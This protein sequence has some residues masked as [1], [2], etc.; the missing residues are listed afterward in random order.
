MKVRTEEVWVTVKTL[1]MRKIPTEIP[2]IRTLIKKIES[3]DDDFDE[4]WEL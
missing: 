4:N 2:T 3:S 1:M